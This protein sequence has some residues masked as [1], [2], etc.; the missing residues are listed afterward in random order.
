MWIGIYV[1]VNYDDM[2]SN[3]KI[4]SYIMNSARKTY[5]NFINYLKGSTI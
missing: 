5:M 1:N 3:V 4:I 2:I